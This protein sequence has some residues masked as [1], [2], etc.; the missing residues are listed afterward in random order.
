MDGPINTQNDEVDVVDFFLTLWESKAIILS[1]IAVGFALGVAVIFTHAPAHESKIF[2]SVEYNLPF[3]QPE[4]VISEFRNEFASE[5]NFISWKN[6]SGE[7]PVNYSDFSLTKVVDD[8]TLSFEGDDQLAELIA[9]EAG[10]FISVRTGEAS[11]ANIFYKY[12][13]FLNEKISE[14]YR[15]RAVAD[16]E[17]FESKFLGF[18]ST[19]SAVVDAVLSLERYLALEFSRSKVFKI[20]NP[21]V[22]VEKSVNVAAILIVCACLGGIIGALLISVRNGIAKRKKLRGVQ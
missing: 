10:A 3:Q 19:D 17:T 8:V 11:I 5:A 20:E 2:I 6:I 21:T 12:S 22:P 13:E 18:P 15:S 7:M 4:E 9:D 16:L 14:A 1:A